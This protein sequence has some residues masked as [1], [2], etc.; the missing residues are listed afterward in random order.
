MRYNIFIFLYKEENNFF[1]KIIFFF[2][3]IYYEIYLWLH[4]TKLYSYSKI[5][6]NINNK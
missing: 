5:N 2:Y 1:A 3:K 4:S 6:V